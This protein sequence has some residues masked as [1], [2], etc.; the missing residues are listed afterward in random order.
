[1][2]FISCFS[3][4]ASSLFTLWHPTIKGKGAPKVCRCSWLKEKTEV[5]GPA[6]AYKVLLTNYTLGMEF[7]VLVSDLPDLSISTWQW[8]LDKGQSEREEREGDGLKRERQR[9]REKER[10]PFLTPALIQLM[11]YVGAQ[12]H[13]G[14]M[15]VSLIAATFSPP[16]RKNFSLSMQIR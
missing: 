7:G 15:A 14:F 5:K 11:G 13:L 16:W 9:G 12:M 10:S 2:H 4:S 8:L 1:M 3:F 6:K